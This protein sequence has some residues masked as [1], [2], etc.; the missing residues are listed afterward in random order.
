MCCQK[1]KW[2]REVV[3]D[4]KFDFVDVKEFKK[5]DAFIIIKYLFLYFVICKIVLVYIA[6]LWTA[7]SLLILDSWSSTITPAIPF[8]YSKWIYVGC[9]FM[10]F[11]LLA[12]DWKKARAIIASK[13]ISYAFTSTIS[14]RYYSLKSFPHYCFFHQIKRQ[15]RMVDIIAFF[16]F[17]TFK[18]KFSSLTNYY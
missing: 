18:G 2:K 16:V 8:I 5:N 6:D 9:I 15:S 14:Y 1:A 3:Q 12:I 7:G 11:L 4:H 13:D 10:S 17:F